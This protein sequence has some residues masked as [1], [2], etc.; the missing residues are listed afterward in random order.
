MKMKKIYNSPEIEILEIS[1]ESIMLT[2]SPETAPG[3]E[4][5]EGRGNDTGGTANEYR[6]DWE[7]IWG[8]M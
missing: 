3:D 7:N 5:D 8:N 4:D 1:V 2:K 6:G